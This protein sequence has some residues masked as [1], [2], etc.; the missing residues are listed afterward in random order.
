VFVFVSHLTVPS[1]DHAS[2]ESHFR[3]RSHLVEGVPGFLY[4]QLLRPQGGAAT[5][6]FV[7]AWENREAFRR[8]MASTE[9][10]QAH[11]REPADIMARTEVRH[12][13]FDVLMDSRLR[14]EWLG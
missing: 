12:E 8:Y 3:D 11:A 6:T 10:A 2:L 1:A 14:P 5:H 4:L 13:A 7:T 9:R